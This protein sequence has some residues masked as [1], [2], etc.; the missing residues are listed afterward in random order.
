MPEEEIFADILKR[1][2]GISRFQDLPRDIQIRERYF[3]ANS[4]RGMRE[5]LM[6][7]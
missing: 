3:C 6:R 7:Q 4:I 2:A 5:Y 1:D